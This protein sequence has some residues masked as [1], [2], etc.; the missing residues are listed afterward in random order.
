MMQKKELTPEELATISGGTD[1]DA[2][3]FLNKMAEKYGTT[4][5]AVLMTMMTPEEII[6]MQALLK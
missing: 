4:N 5:P 6:Q 1:K 2:A 3:D